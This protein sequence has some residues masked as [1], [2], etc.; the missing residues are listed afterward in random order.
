MINLTTLCVRGVRIVGRVSH[1][2]IALVYH[3][4][5]CAISAMHLA[6]SGLVPDRG[7]LRT[8]TARIS[9]GLTSSSL[10]GIRCTGGFH[11]VCLGSLGS[12]STLTLFS[13]FALSLFL[14]L[15]GFPF[16]SDFLEFCNNNN[17]SGPWFHE[18]NK[19]GA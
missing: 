10:R 15:A 5:C 12:S 9:R 17:Q 8:D 1:L 3:T 13:S 2:A 11:L 18:A 7:K 19:S 16:L 4:T 14:L 6:V